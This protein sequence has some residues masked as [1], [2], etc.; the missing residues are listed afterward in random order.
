M[1]NISEGTLILSTILSRLVVWVLVGLMFA[2][3]FIYNRLDKRN[4]L[5]RIRTLCKAYR[6]FMILLIF[7]RVIQVAGLFLETRHY[8]QPSTFGI[9]L[10][11][12]FV[13][14][15]TYFYFKSCRYYLKQQDDKE[16]LADWYFRK[17]LGLVKKQ[18][19]Q[20]AYEC[21]QRIAELTPDSV[22]SWGA[23]ANF[24]GFFFEDFQLA[25]DYL[26]KA[27]HIYEKNNKKASDL[28][29]L[30]HYKGQIK[31]LQND[32]Q[33]AIEHLKKAYEL[34]PTD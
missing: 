33:S 15:I 22:N 29:I 13:I 9:I 8:T 14:I 1:T 7:L 17:H 10:E 16:I 11:W 5:N 23:L 2:G 27:Q 3:W 28:A 19:I 32:H 12:A 21:S 31:Q 24:S 6:I 20:A 4:F 30:E 18:Q 26:E 34:D 25:N